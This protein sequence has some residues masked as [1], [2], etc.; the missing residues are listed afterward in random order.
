MF[1]SLD[2]D[3]LDVEALENVHRKFLVEQDDADRKCATK[4]CRLAGLHRI[5]RDWPRRRFVGIAERPYK[6]RK[7]SWAASCG[8]R[9]SDKCNTNHGTARREVRPLWL[10]RPPDGTSFGG[11]STKRSAVSTAA[12]RTKRQL[13]TKW[14]IGG[15]PF[16]RVRCDEHHDAAWALP[17]RLRE[18]CP[19]PRHHSSL[20]SPVKTV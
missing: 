13:Q 3:K 4:D 20:A 2:N 15:F 19:A 6:M 7:S 16:D 11:M 10:I 18:M 1:L 17:V 14:V 8:P 5:R 12:C 9:A